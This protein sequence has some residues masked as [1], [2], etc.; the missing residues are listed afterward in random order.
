MVKVKAWNIPYFLSI[1]IVSTT[2]WWKLKDCA[3]DNMTAPF[4][5]STTLWWKLK[6]LQ[7]LFS[8]YAAVSTTL[9]WKLKFSR[10]VIHC[11]K[12]CFNHPMVKV[13]VV[14]KSIKSINIK[15]STTLWWKL[16]KRQE[17]KSSCLFVSTTLWWKLKKSVVNQLLI[18]VWVSTT[19]W[20]KLKEFKLS[21]IYI[22]AMSF[23]HPMVKVKAACKPRNRAYKNV[24]TT[25]WWKLKWGTSSLRRSNSFCFN[26]PMVKVKVYFLSIIIFFTT[27]FQ[28]PY[29]ES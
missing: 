17:L 13:K 1:F 2:L 10:R 22:G 15:V 28:P 4:P 3:I 16:K 24:S 11:V 26:H 14:N 18:A 7:T 12:N 6:S 21:F 9:W 23:N 29:G 5:V 25:L 8:Y 27:A 19:L 20:W